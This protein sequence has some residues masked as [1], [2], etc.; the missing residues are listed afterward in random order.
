[1]FFV[2]PDEYIALVCLVSLFALVVCVFYIIILFSCEDIEHRILRDLDSCR[3][4]C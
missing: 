1:V 4:G 2:T 3:D